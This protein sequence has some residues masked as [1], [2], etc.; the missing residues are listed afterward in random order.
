MLGRANPTQPSLP[1]QSGTDAGGSV[2]RDR[3]S[4]P[5]AGAGLD[6]DGPSVS[7]DDALGNGKPESS[8]A[9]FAIP[10]I[11]DADEPLEHV[12]PHLY[13]ESGAFVYHRGD[14]IGPV[15]LEQEPH[16]S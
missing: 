4:D 5:P 6:G 7:L 2:E 14:C 3:E 9:G 1:A 15:S 12:I 16:L 10:G 13:W 8:P 11:V